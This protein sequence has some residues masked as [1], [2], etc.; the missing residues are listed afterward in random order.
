MSMPRRA[1]AALALVSAGA[2]AVPTL[3]SAQS[4]GPRDITVR[5]KVQSIRFV[6]QQR[7]TKGDRLAPG[8]RLRTRQRLFDDANRPIGALFTDCVNVGASA[9]VFAA[10]LQCV[11]T[12]RFADGQV[13]LTGLLHVGAVGTSAP[14]AGGSGAYRGA[15]GEVTTGKAVNGYD[16]D[17]LHL[18]G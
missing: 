8:D 3:T 12:Y 15:R 9:R 17:V 5:E 6:H 11:A 13:V 10:T 1:L 16:V 4:T 18:D 7:S 2:V 14:I